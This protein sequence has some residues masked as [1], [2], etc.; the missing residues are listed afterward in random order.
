MTLADRPLRAE[1][2]PAPYTFRQSVWKLGIR[3]KFSHSR[4]HAGA[5]ADEAP[6]SPVLPLDPAKRPADDPSYLLDGC[7]EEIENLWGMC[8][9]RGLVAEEGPLESAPGGLTMTESSR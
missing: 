4:T 7:R 2:E 6:P 8:V 3:S 9:S 5:A 1:T